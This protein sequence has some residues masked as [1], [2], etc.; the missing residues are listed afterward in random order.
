[1]MTNRSDEDDQIIEKGIDIHK[2]SQD[3][4]QTIIYQQNWNDESK[5][6]MQTTLKW[7]FINFY[8]TSKILH[9]QN[10]QTNFIKTIDIEF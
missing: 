3:D 6:P 7:K 9:P 10:F 2:K 4:S 8:H 5:L 1:M